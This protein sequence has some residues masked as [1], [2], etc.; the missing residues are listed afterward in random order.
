MTAA[1][2]ESSDAFEPEAVV[3]EITPEGVPFALVRVLR[4]EHLRL[5]PPRVTGERRADLGMAMK[6][7]GV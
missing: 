2:H 1:G 7:C 5:H 3:D 6:S 4:E